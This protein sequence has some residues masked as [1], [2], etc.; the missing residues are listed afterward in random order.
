MEIEDTNSK[1]LNAPSHFKCYTIK[2][3]KIILQHPRREPQN[4]GESYDGPKNSKQ[5]N[6]A[7]ENEEPKH[8]WVAS[9][10]EE[11]EEKC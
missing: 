4:H 9:K 1:V 2:E 10:L 11:K 3:R 8:V 5:V 6:L 7:G